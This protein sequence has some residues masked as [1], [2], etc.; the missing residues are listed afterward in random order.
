MNQRR[1]RMPC[2]EWLN[3]KSLNRRMLVHLG[4]TSSQ[5]DRVLYNY[6]D[7]NPALDKRDLLNTGETIRMSVN[8]SALDRQPDLMQIFPCV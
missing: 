4:E 8:Y 5:Y 3:V 2:H 7:F 6:F 1:L